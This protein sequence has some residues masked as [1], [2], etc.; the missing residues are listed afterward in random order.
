M[1]RIK[2]PRHD[3]ERRQDRRGRLS[4][5]RIGQATVTFSRLLLYYLRVGARPI[6]SK[7]SALSSDDELMIRVNH[8]DLDKLAVLYERYSRALFAFFSR[9]P[10]TP[11]PMRTR[12]IRPV[13]SLERLSFLEPE[14]KV[15]YRNGQGAAGQE[16]MDYLEFIARVTSHMRDKGQVMVRYYGPTPTPTEGRSGRQASPLQFKGWPKTICASP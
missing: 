13:L 15:S 6:S 7:E 4:F 14:G 11:K 5:P 10:W 1:V 8:G 12:S 3:E 9:L 2:S 16:I